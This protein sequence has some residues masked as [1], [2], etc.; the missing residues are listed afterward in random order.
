MNIVSIIKKKALKQELTEEE[1]KYFVDCVVK[2]AIDQC[3][4]GAMLMAFFLNDINNTE[5]RVI[6]KAVVESG[7]IL[8]YGPSKIVVDKHSTGGVG[9]K[10]SIPLVPALKAVADFVIPMVSGRALDFTGGTLDKLESI[11][12][13]SAFSYEPAKLLEMGNEFGCFI[14]GSDDLAPVDS[15]LYKARDVTATVDNDKLIISSIISKKAAAGVKY[16]ILDLKVGN[17]SFFTSI[18]RAKQFGEQFINVAKLMGINCRVLLTRMSAP[19]GKYVGNSLEIIESIDCLKGKGPSDLQ[20]IIEHI[21]SHLLQMTKKTDSLKQGRKIIADA[22]N[23]GTGLQIFKKMLV[24][25]G[26]YDSVA[27][28][29]CY[30]DPTSILPMAKNIKEIKSLTAGYVKSIDGMA[31]AKVCNVL[32]AGRQFSGQKIDPGVGVHLLVSEGD[33]VDLGKV[34]LNLHHN[35]TSLNE[36]LVEDLQKSIEI[37][38][39]PSL[40]VNDIILD[41]IDLADG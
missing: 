19:I 39:K 9:D 14:V 24:V 27:E 22:L 21:G 16:L 8:D 26:I 34:I 32:G 7:F 2:N 10:V 28:E 15:V 31:I 3:Q 1:I 37:L 36:K 4:I 23:N 20:T 5:V 38:E 6:T 17:A 35:N 25:Q 12:G 30:G 29:L 11:P 40:E 33:Y 41:Y 13:Y 18:E